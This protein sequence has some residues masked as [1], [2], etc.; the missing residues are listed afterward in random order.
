MLSDFTEELEAPPQPSEE[1]TSE[2]EEL[3]E[4]EDLKSDAD[5]LVRELV[6]FAS[7]IVNVYE[8]IIRSA[9]DFKEELDRE[10]FINSIRAGVE[11]TG[12]L[13]VKL[14][15]FKM[16]LLEIVCRFSEDIHSVFKHYLYEY[17][18]A[19]YHEILNKK[20]LIVNLIREGRPA[21]ALIMFIEYISDI[22]D[23]A[24]QLFSIA[25]GLAES[26][27]KYYEEFKQYYEQVRRQYEK[28][29]EVR[30]GLL[31]AVI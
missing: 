10:G 11:E 2:E 25:R 8:S 15:Q 5:L 31:P 24:S 1:L 20:N 29:R 6:N 19:K 13:I 17:L 3:R 14:D 18:P 28:Y 30:S 26:I 27:G 9:R 4:L 22:L 16:K 23:I 12:N 7:R 21:T